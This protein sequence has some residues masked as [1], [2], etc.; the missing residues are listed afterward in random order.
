MDK[1]MAKPKEEILILIA[2]SDEKSL[3][4]IPILLHKLGYVTILE[5]KDREEA[6][7]VIKTKSR[8]NTGMSGLLGGA[9]PKEATD[10]D[11]IMIDADIAPGG[12]VKLIAEIRKRFGADKPAILF[13]GKA[14]MDEVLTQALKAGANDAITKPFSKDMLGIKLSV[15]LGS[16]RAPKIQSFSFT[17]PGKSAQTQAKP[18]KEEP[19]V[20]AVQP[21]AVVK[22]TA[23]LPPAMEPVRVAQSA[24][25]VKVSGP[26]PSQTTKA[27]TSFVGRNTKKTYSTDG[28]PTAV[29]VDGKIDG[30]Y[31]EQV[32]V[33]GGGQNCYWARRVGEQERV[34]LEYLSAKGA[35]T[36][37]EAK[38]VPLEEFM[39]SFVLCDTGNCHIMERL[40]GEGR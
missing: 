39:Y 12:G 38:V 14:G 28:D 21:A 17:P 2:D 9:A 27:G 36:G 7:K 23:L 30:H 1:R 6:E 31:H 29:L 25:A 11:L 10:I 8:S 35:P 4:I 20:R 22:P 15:L 19:P 33:I 40:A 3:H 32:N 24:S 13:T 37:M 26:G 5:A 18:K 34:R 16:D